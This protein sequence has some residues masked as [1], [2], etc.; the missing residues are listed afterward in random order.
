MHNPIGDSD[1]GSN[2]GKQVS[3]QNGGGLVWR[4]TAHSFV[5]T[6][7]NSEAEWNQLLERRRMAKSSYSV[8]VSQVEYW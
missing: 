2:G 1:L 7:T 3:N 6:D 8:K 4:R 5:V